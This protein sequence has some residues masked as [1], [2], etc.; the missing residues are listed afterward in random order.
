MENRGNGQCLWLSKTQ[1]KKEHLVEIFEVDDKGRKGCLL[2]PESVE[3][4][5]WIIFFNMLNYKDEAEKYLSKA[6][7]VEKLTPT[8][9][10]VIP[11]LMAK[12]QKRDRMQ[13]FNL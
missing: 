5:S 3:L 7:L 9:L 11:T 2:V 1:N 12:I 6:K 13:K 10:L 8:P 4:T